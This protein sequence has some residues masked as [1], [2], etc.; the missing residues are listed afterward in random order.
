[1]RN[2]D[3]N[4]ENIVI[5]KALEM[6]VNEG[7]DGFSMQKLARAAKVSPATLYIYYKDKED[8]I[9]QLGIEESKKM[10]TAMFLNFN[11]EISFAEGLK[12]QWENRAKYVLENSISTRFYEQIKNSPYQAKIR[13]LIINEFSEKMRKF[14]LKRLKT[15]NSLPCLPK[16]F[17][18]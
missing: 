16:F 7:F 1:M 9:M 14:W 3:E 12:L 4:K 5:E 6:L 2:R 18:R 15:K 8:L 17:G 11:E 13:E 10:A